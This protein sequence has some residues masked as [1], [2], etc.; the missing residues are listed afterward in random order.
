MRIP[1]YVRASFPLA[2]LGVLLL[3]AIPPAHAQRAEAWLSLLSKLDAQ[4]KATVLRVTNYLRTTSKPKTCDIVPPDVPL[5]CPKEGGDAAVQSAISQFILAVEDPEQGMA[6]WIL[7]ITRRRGG[8]ASSP[9]PDAL[10]AEEERILF[11]RV[12]ALILRV[13]SK[14][15]ALMRQYR[16]KPDKY[17]AVVRLATAVEK[18]SAL[19]DADPDD[20]SDTRKAYMETIGDF[21]YACIDPLLKRVRE[22]HEYTLV[23]VVLQMQRNAELVG[24]KPPVDLESLLSKVEKAMRFKLEL[25]ETDTNAGWYDFVLKS[26]LY[27][28]PQFSAG[29]TGLHLVGSGTSDYE[30]TDWH[31]DGPQTSN[32][33][34]TFQAA[35][36][37]F[38]P[39]EGTAT[40]GLNKFFSEQ[41]RFDWLKTRRRQVGN[42]KGIW[43]GYFG[44]HE[45][46]KN[47]GFV[48][49]IDAGSFHNK[50]AVVID[51]TFEMR[52]QNPDGYPDSVVTFR[53][54]MTH[55][56]K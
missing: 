17:T 10:T 12:N 3:V 49:L 48:F 55:E 2:V 16:G 23:P 11:D 36:T 50:E 40:V 43:Y 15:E 18:M 4:D 44:N 34:S 46:T 37:D 21:C 30:S 28:A 14:A 35:I 53:I 52:Y 13:R 38:N 20:P 45:D 39:C 51:K 25:V 8:G 29:A 9:A 32:T 26:E 6:V 22:E 5:G 41:E 24:Y 27:V 54:R 19:V 56:P 7:D 31:G 1:R 33:A 47:G 42:Q